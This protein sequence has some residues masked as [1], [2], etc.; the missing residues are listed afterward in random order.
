[1]LVRKDH[2]LSLLRQ[3]EGTTKII[4]FTSKLTLPA[5]FDIQIAFIGKLL[6]DAAIAVA[7]STSWP[8]RATGTA[9]VAVTVYHETRC[10][11]VGTERKSVEISV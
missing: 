11:C 3:D 8:I 5:L 6:Y 9:N 1:L 7:N 10:S 2:R 4:I